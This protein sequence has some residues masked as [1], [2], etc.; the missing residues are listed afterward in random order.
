MTDRSSNWRMRWN[1][2]QKISKSGQPKC[3]YCGCDFPRA[4]EINHKDPTAKKQ[5]KISGKP[6]SGSP[7]YRRILSGERSTEDLEVAC[8]V[9]NKN[10][11]FQRKYGLKW[12]VTYEGAI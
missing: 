12:R 7:F 3:V 1:A 2:L 4:L 6:V 9:C 11:Y 8:G 5:E 10:H